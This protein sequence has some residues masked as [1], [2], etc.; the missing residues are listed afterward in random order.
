MFGDL[1][2]NNSIELDFRRWK[3][4]EKLSNNKWEEW[5]PGTYSLEWDSQEC[6][7]CLNDAVC[8][9][10]TAINVNSGYW[11]KTHN[12]TSIIEWLNKDACKG[13]YLQSSES[14]T[15]W[16]QGYKGN[17]WT[18][19]DIMDSNKYQET[20]EFTC[21]KWP[22]PVLNAIRVFG[23]G[24]IVFIYFMVII[25]VNVRKTT[26]SDVSILLRILTN[27]AQLV[28]T[29]IS[30]S[31]KYPESFTDFLIPARNVGDSS[32]AF[33]SFDCFATDYEIKGPFNSSSF[34]K[35]FL[36]IWLPILLFL[37]VT[38]IW[39]FIYFIKPSWVKNFTRYLVISFISIVFLL[40]PKLAQ[41]GLSIF[42]WIKID[43]NN[44]RVRI[45]S[46]IKCYSGEHLKWWV[47]LGL[48]ILAI[49]VVGMP[50]FA[51]ITMHKNIRKK[52]DNKI[53]EYFLILNQGL[54]EKHFYWEFVN[55]LRKVLILLSFVF[56]TN[57]QI[58][59]STSLLIVTWRIQNYL[60]PYKNKEKNGIEMFGINVGIVTL[61]WGLIYN[62]EETTN[63][64]L[65]LLTLLT[66]ISLNSIFI[67]KWSSWFLCV[68]GEKY[69]ILLKVCTIKWYSLINIQRISSKPM[70][71]FT[72]KP[73]Q[74]LPHCFYRFLN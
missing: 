51:L 64:A 22:D 66:M 67:L 62:N 71:K 24:F 33:L 73:Y 36:L 47:L 19:W 27:Y 4:G 72:F 26:E 63:N 29:T 7:T 5:S 48:P 65:N 15:E 60:Q 32:S 58:V 25:V 10:G 30:F 59:F 54:R 39:V 35:L 21:Q 13:G 70:L 3:P 41:S 16:A 1:I 14:P 42:R 45:D 57:F 6:T 46:D 31:T 37:L 2:S 74:P 55:S 52:G 20:G 53:K 18:K 68:L 8:E 28:T 9:G 12:S 69:P 44:L 17:L 34:L 43:D 23:V 40:H 56:P 61:F 11:R 49:W 38:M 50:V